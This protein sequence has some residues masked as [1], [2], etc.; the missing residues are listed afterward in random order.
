M[1]YNILNFPKKIFFKSKVAQKATVPDANG[2][3]Y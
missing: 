3:V 2:V 1:P